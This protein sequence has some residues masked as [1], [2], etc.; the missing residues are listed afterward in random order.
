M[1]AIQ[2][3]VAAVERTSLASR[4]T[5]LAVL[6]VVAHAVVIAAAGRGTTGA[7]LSNICQLA[8]VSLATALSAVAACRLRGESRPFW[9]LTALG[10]ASWTGGQAL[11]MP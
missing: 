5:H 8:A 7:L 10:L 2:V 9:G 1:A 11:Y 4:V 6:L 3:W